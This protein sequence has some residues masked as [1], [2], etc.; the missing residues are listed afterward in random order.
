MARMRVHFSVDS[1]W[2]DISDSEIKAMKFEDIDELA[3]YLQEMA[4]DH[5]DFTN[6]VI[7]SDDIEAIAEE[8]GVGEQNG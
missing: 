5:I 6:I 4:I 1:D 2:F 8:C 7:E 3:E